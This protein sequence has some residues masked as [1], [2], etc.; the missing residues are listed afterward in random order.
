MMNFIH[1]FQNQSSKYILTYLQRWLWYHLKEIS[2]LLK[3]L[4]VQNN[5]VAE[6]FNIYVHF[7]NHLQ[8]QMDLVANYE[9]NKMRI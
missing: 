9:R 2:R 7:E 8:D 5:Y 3:D 4:Y 6:D 1:G